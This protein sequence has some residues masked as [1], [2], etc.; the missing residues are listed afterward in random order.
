MRNRISFSL[1]LISLFYTFKPVYE[2]NSFDHFGI[3]YRGVGGGAQFLLRSPGAFGKIAEP[4]KW[5]MAK[6]GVRGS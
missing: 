1:R 3:G 5:L 4:T 2:N 6:R